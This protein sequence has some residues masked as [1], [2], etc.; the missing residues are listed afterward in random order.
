MQTGRLTKRIQIIGQVKT[1]DEHG[2][3]TMEEAV[4]FTCWA[5]IKPA[6]GKVLYEMERKDSTEYVVITIRW[7]PNLTHDLKVKYQDHTYSID[8][9][10]DPYMRHEALELYCTEDVRG[11]DH[12]E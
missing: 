8:N 10:V 5:E 12:G 2:F 6:R 3:D 1:L 4:L 7:R 11:Q 9:I